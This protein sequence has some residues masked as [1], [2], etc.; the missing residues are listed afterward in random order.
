MRSDAVGKSDGVT[1]RVFI[2]E[3]GGIK[4]VLDKN[5]TSDA[6]DEHR[7]TS[8]PSPAA[9]SP[10]ASKPIPAPRETP[11]STSPS[12]AIRR[13]LPAH[14]PVGIS[15]RL[16]QILRDPRLANETERRTDTLVNDS[17]LGVRPSVVGLVKNRIS[18]RGR[19][20]IFEASG[21]GTIVR[22]HLDPAKSFLEGISVEAVAK[23]EVGIDDFLSGLFG[24]KPRRLFYPCHGSGPGG[25]LSRDLVSCERER[26]Q[27][28][29]TES[30]VIGKGH[31]TMETTLKISGRSLVIETKGDDKLRV[32]SELRYGQLRAPLRRVIRLPYLT[33]VPVMYLPDQRLYVSLVPDWTASSASALTAESAPYGAKTDGSRNA[34]RERAFLTVSPSLG[35]VLAEPPKPASPFLKEIS[36]RLVYDIWGGKFEENAGWLRE[37]KSYGLDR[38]ILLYHVWQRGG[39]DNEYPTVMPANA[40]LGGDEGMKAL[41]ATAREVGCKICLHE[42]YV[43]FYP[44]SEAYNANNVSLSSKGEPV[45]AWYNQGTK[46]QSYAYK[47]NAIL[48]Y[49]RR[50]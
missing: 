36:D 10:S 49:A 7:E 11:A 38:T 43:D 23:D 13:S 3:K 37:L 50:F 16:D 5:Y 33:F 28:I 29:L 31:Y 48:K 34:L 12:G 17:A 41:C 2:G 22:Y 35:E 4:K 8:A 42:N 9:P 39:Y 14:T 44:N 20:W 6:W 46:Q 24:A 26:D 40:K 19:E 47:P 32:F 15:E 18:K 1:F 30:Y 25:G 27:V 45:K 21:G